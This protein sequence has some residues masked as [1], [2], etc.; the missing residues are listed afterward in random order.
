MQMRRG[1]RQDG[2]HSS[3]QMLN[4]QT[5][6]D[7]HG[8]QRLQHFLLV[9]TCSFPLHRYRRASENGSV[10]NGT[11]SAYPAGSDVNVASGASVNP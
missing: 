2:S 7:Q 8:Q 1:L 9:H 6:S 11:R 5:H 3:F 10:P 4:R